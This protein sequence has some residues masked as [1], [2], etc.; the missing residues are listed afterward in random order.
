MSI[1]RN[2][3]LSEYTFLHNG[4]PM[5]K[6]L[7]NGTTEL[8]TRATPYTVVFTDYPISE[9]S[10]IACEVKS[11]TTTAEHY[12]ISALKSGTVTFANIVAS[13]TLPTQKCNKV[14]VKYSASEYAMGDINGAEIT[15]GASNEYL[16]FDCAG[17]EF[18]LELSVYDNTATYPA[19][20]TITEV[21]FYY[22][23][24]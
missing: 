13:V 24:V 11:C 2:G 1:L 22:E 7:H 3:K 16:V 18:T 17:D 19:T 20:L 10:S 15:A 8:W 9:V 6:V 23:H 14:K 4:I 21:S 12:Q 5:D